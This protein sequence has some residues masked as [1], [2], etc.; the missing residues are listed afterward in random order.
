VQI[1]WTEE[2]VHVEVHT[3][4]TADDPHLLEH[5]GVHGA[6]SCLLMNVPSLNT[7]TAAPLPCVA[8]AQLQQRMRLQCNL[9]CDCLESA[10][11]ASNGEVMLVDQ[12]FQR[13]GCS[14]GDHGTVQGSQGCEWISATAP[15]ASLR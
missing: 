6:T 5:D 15:D 3:R 2:Q 11:F 7:D 10:P 8:A 4:P 14:G 9:D 13:Q 1:R 12:V